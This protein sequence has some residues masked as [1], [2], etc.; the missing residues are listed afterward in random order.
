MKLQIGIFLRVAGGLVLAA[1]FIVLLLLKDTGSGPRLLDNTL[2]DLQQQ[3]FKT[4]VSQFNFSTTPAEQERQSALLSWASNQS[5]EL[6]REWPS[7]EE[8]I[9]DGSRVVIWQQD[10]LRWPHATGAD[11]ND[12]ITWGEIGEPLDEA[13]AIMDAACQAALAGSI[14]FNLNASH[15]HAML[16]PHVS[17]MKALEEI[18][19]Y[20][21]MVALHDGH[22]DSAW[23]NLLAATR[24]VTAWDV[25]P[26]EVSHLVR[27][28][29]TKFACDATWQA[30]QKTNWTEKQLVQ[31]QT[32]WEGVEFFSRL[33]ETDEFKLASDVAFYDLSRS[34]HATVKPGGWGNGG[35]FSTLIRS[36]SAVWSEL[37]YRWDQ[38]SY[39]RTGQ[40]EEERDL[41]LYDRDQEIQ[42]RNAAKASTWAQMS[43]LP[44]VTNKVP[45]KSKF[46]FSPGSGRSRNIAMALQE[47]EEGFLGKAAVAEA[48]RRIVV[49]ALALERYHGR[50]GRYPETLGALSPEFT[51]AEP[52]DFM[53]GQPLKYRVTDDGRYEIYS[54]GLDCVD[55]GGTPALEDQPNQASIIS[56]R[57]GTGFSVPRGDIVWPVPAERSNVTSMR[58]QALNVI[59]KQTDDV[60]LAKAQV[61]WKHA[62][63]HQADAEKLLAMPATDPPD[64]KIDGRPISEWLQN[65]KTAGPGQWPLRRLLSLKQVLTGDEPE[66]ATFE[67]PISYEALKRVGELYLLIDTNNDDSEDGCVVQ[68]MSCRQA[69]NGD[70][71]LVWQT[72][73][74][75]PGK[76]AM[77]V[78][79]DLHGGVGANKNIV[80]PPL[81]FAVTNLCQFS[82]TDNQFDPRLGASFHLK[83]PEANGRYVLKCV[84]TNGA[85][86]KTLA[87]ETSDGIVT[88]HWDLID[89]QGRRYSD[90]FF[91]SVWIITLPDSG[92]TQTLKGP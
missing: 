6:P 88:D 19:A 47:G 18:F 69:D 17:R 39:W 89:E 87:G 46:R 25:E 80:G 15:G 90:N 42:L 84:T 38:S 82:I 63:N 36:P 48:R 91:N 26:S 41:L 50:H 68:Q 40:F 81:P 77:R 66:Q 31:L 71:L 55:D 92:R 86:L 44:G 20:R 14:R 52:I 5:L 60:A 51:K 34:E 28:S 43:A 11:G 74:D 49:T 56:L 76:H 7:L 53:N 33:P 37:R 8:T 72:I 64:V 24:L 35:F 13:K 10:M 75:S 4:N 57:A 70:C 3:G 23:T 78:G 21:A 83:L 61:Q 29:M 58:R 30:L 59:L 9:S 54:V 12:Q 16:L 85:L 45:F 62:A 73:Y 27:F 1:G 22:Q 2:K 65:K 32:E 79:L 67:L